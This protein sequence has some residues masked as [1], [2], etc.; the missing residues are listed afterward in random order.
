[1]N[2]IDLS[3]RLTDATCATLQQNGITH[4]G[5]YL[6]NSWK[7]LTPSE[8]SS[9]QKSGLH[10]FSIY[11]QGGTLASYFKKEQGVQDAYV[12][13]KLAQ[14]Y[15]QP[16]GTAIYFA[17]DYDAQP[18]DYAGILNYFQG[19]KDTLSSYKVGVY[20][21]YEV[22]QLIQ[23]K[24]LAE[25]YFQTY[26]WSHGQHAKNI[27][28]CQY[29]N[30]VSKFGLQVD[31][32]NVENVSCGTWTDSK[33]TVQTPTFKPLMVV[34]VLQQ[35]DVRELPDHTSD[36]I[37]DVKPPNIYNVVERSGDWHRIV[38]NNDGDVGWVDGNNG[39]NLYW[40]DNPALNPQTQKYV[41]KTGDTFTKI[42]K[43]FKTNIDYLMTIN[44]SVS[45]PNKIF[46]GQV[47][48]VP[49]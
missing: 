24:G 4:V 42:A 33:E 5:R 7:G 21:K 39:Q 17:V 47:L 36:Y 23:S 10:L 46:V 40:I 25:Y 2:G 44:P 18:N 9:I 29:Q 26:A 8:V 20:G 31:L 30:D 38:L 16:E 32:V 27:H 13:Y 43:I 15:G 12:S 34:K 35:T 14:S 41:I 22:I 19:L 45:N 48:N 37:Q 49:K 6:S 1:M 28:L 3:T 11:E